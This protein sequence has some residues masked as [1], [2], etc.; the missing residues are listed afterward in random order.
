MPMTNER[1]YRKAQSHAYAI[2]EIIAGA[3]KQYDGFLVDSFISLF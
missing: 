3:N 2:K 1:P